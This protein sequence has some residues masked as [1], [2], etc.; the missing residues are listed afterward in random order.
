MTCI[1]L[2]NLIVEYRIGKDK[3][4]D[5]SLYQI[6]EDGSLPTTVDSI[7]SQVD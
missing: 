4:E 2:H 7:Q 5:S 3:E 1:L 6:V